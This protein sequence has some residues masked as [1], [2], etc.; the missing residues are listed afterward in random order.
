MYTTLE[1]DSHALFMELSRLVFDGTP[2]LHLANFLHMITTMAESGATEEQVEFF[3]LNSQKVAKLPDKES[4]WSLS[5]TLSLAEN[6]EFPE[7]S[8]AS[9]VSNGQ[10]TKKSRKTGNLPSWPPVDWK[11]TPA[12]SNELA[13]GFN[14]TQSTAQ[15]SNGSG[16]KRYDGSEG[17]DSPNSGAPLETN[18]N[19]SIGNHLAASTVSLLPDSDMDGQLS[20][21]CDP[22]ESSVKIAIDPADL[23]LL[24]DDLKNGSLELSNRDQLSTGLNSFGSKLIPVHLDQPYS[25]FNSFG[26]SQRDQLLT[27]TPNSAQALRTGKLG[28]L[29]AFKHF[30]CN[31]GKK[32]KWV[33]KD[34]ETGLPYDLLVEDEGGRFEYIEVKATRSARK[35]WFNI[36]TREWQ[37]AAEKGEAFC[38][39]HVLLSETNARLTIYRNPVKLCQLGK[40][41]L[42][43]LMPRQ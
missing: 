24:P 6:N 43:V 36:S 3:I 13:N 32:V 20:N 2:D 18:G 40:L 42:V 23:T 31:L 29:A 22:A 8:S 1:S 16:K 21:A 7:A 11:M 26:F 30:G 9:D 14:R 19:S 35:D 10:P 5:R 38:I 39:A 41:Q 4:V 25:E 33:N 28:E 37:F 12:F 17:V 27:G 34:N 15:P